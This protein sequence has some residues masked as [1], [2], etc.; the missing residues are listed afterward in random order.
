MSSPTARVDRSKARPRGAAA[1]AL[2]LSLLAGCTPELPVPVLSSVNPNWGYNGEETTVDVVGAGFY[3]IVQVDSSQRTD[4]DDHFEIWLQTDPEVEL[5]DVTLEDHEH[6]G[7]RV[8]SGLEVGVY[9]LRVVS[10]TGTESWLS[11]AFE[12]RNTRGDEL[13]VSSSSGLLEWQVGD[14]ASLTVELLD[15]GG[16]RVP[17]D[18]LI[19]VTVADE[20]MDLAVFE[21]GTL[22]DQLPL[23]D[24][25]GITG[26]LG[27]DGIG[28]VGV[29]A[30]EPTEQL[31][32]SFSVADA[33]SPVRG[34]A[35]DLSYVAGDAAS[36]VI[37]LPSTVFDAVAGEP[38]EVLLQAVDSQGNPVDDAAGEFVILETCPGGSYRG[39]VDFSDGNELVEL[40]FTQATGEGCDQNSVLAVG[41]IDGV[42]VEAESDGFEVLP[43]EAQGLA[44]EV[45]PLVIAAGETVLADIQ[46]IDTHGNEVVEAEGALTV[47]VSV[48][49]GAAV[50]PADQDC[51]PMEDGDAYCLVRLDSAG[52]EVVLLIST[53]GPDPLSGVSQPFTVTAGPAVELE[54]GLDTTRAV[55][56]E[57]FGLS[58]LASDELGNG[59]LL[60]IEGE[61]P[62]DFEGSVGDIACTWIGSGIPSGTELFSCTATLATGSEQLTVSLPSYG[63]AAS[64]DSF[65]VVNGPLALVLVD[66]A[67]T[68][69]VEAGQ[70]VPAQLTATDAWGNAYLVQDD[71]VVD[72]ADLSGEVSPG[73]VSLSA[74]GTAFVD[75][76]VTVAREEDRVLVSQDGVELGTSEPFD[77]L[78]AE[79]ESLVLTAPRTWAWVDEGIS[80][81][82]EALDPYGNRDTD[83][84]ED[85]TISS[86]GEL[87]DERIWRGMEAG[88]GQLSWTFHSR[89]LADVITATDGTLSTTLTLDALD[90]ACTD[91]PTADLLVGGDSSTRLCIIEAWGRTA[92]VTVDASGSTAGGGALVAYH[93]DDGEG[94]WTRS[95]SASRVESWS[96][97]GHWQL[98]VLLAD[99]YACGDLAQ[100]EVWVGHDDGSAVGPV[101]VSLDEDTL[102]TEGSKSYAD[103][104][105]VS[106]T[107]R[108]CAEDAAAYAPVQLR[109]D[110]GQLDPA[111]VGSTGSGLELVLEDDGTGQATWSV[112]G[113]LYDGV[114][115]LHAGVAGGQAYGSASIDVEGDLQPP[116]LLALDPSGTWTADF[117]SVQMHFSEEILASSVQASALGLTDPDGLE[118]E[119]LDEDLELSADQRSLTLWLP[120]TAEGSAGAWLF[121]LHASSRN[122]L[123]DL[124]GN[125]IDGAWSGA[126]SSFALELGD[127]ADDSP[128]LVTCSADR[129]SFRPDGDDGSGGEA[130]SVQVEVEATTA[131][132]WWLL[133]V[134][135]EELV[136]QEWFAHSG[137]TSASI[138]WQG[139]DQE[140]RIVDNGSYD[141][142]IVAADEHWNPSPDCTVQVAIDNQVAP[143]E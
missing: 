84:A 75:V 16:E 18:V 43:A 34:D 35:I 59:V 117:D 42:A 3:P 56:G 113:S 53:S 126:A 135:G 73:S 128:E 71:P 19:E 134:E 9:D 15:P 74:E 91:P 4:I 80:L 86:A 14:F 90:A 21:D 131:P 116:H 100:A 137:G 51:N 132:A 64:T 1:A 5:I 40:T 89:G 81:T 83:Y 103:E 79:A 66:L 114:G 105:L 129:S 85:L 120:E 2:A 124:E 110:L 143:L 65:E 11:S 125:I 49:G 99:R 52:D 111:T 50:A 23:P 58:L 118:V 44:I 119:L 25:S 101:V 88:E 37:E 72:L 93:F 54:V 31:R 33:D 22:A 112:A 138:T 27:P 140:G 48:D 26:R 108:T 6:L 142:T 136:Y 115:T 133:Q 96:E 82:V 13:S 121:E 68:T 92:S 76:E 122:S 62:V 123:R 60:D 95:T 46:A 41:F 78:P 130:D 63:L 77:V 32:V 36:L 57:P 45:D 24:G 139:R 8:P 55:A 7:A 61:D 67:G 47:Q 69:Q 12:V 98:Q 141:L 97:P 30:T 39:T 29:T 104:T 87:G 102:Y 17:E 107:A 109:V 38:F 127:V 106:L 10:P 28:I 94:T 70:E 20:D